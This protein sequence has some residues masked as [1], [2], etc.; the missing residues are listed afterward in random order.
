M[1]GT[2]VPNRCDGGHVAIEEITVEEL[3]QRLEAGVVL[4][5]VRAA[6][7]SLEIDG[8]ALGAHEVANQLIEQAVLKPTDP[9]LGR[10]SRVDELKEGERLLAIEPELDRIERQ[11]PVDREVPAHV[12]QEVDVI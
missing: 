4:L 1:P 9:L 12:A 11:H 2:A 5:D 6:E 10:K 3:A 7:A 8:A